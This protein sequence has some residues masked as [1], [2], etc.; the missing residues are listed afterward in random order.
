M[1]SKLTELLYPEHNTVLKT[2]HDW[3]EYIKRYKV[4]NNCPRLP[5]AIAVP[6]KDFLD[7]VNNFKQVSH[8]NRSRRKRLISLL[9]HAH[10]TNYI[11][12][13]SNPQD[14][15]LFWL[16]THA[17]NA[18]NALL[19]EYHDFCK[20]RHEQNPEPYETWTGN[21]PKSADNF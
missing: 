21:N 11:A 12:R 9:T 18:Y 17:P 2:A 6:T 19:A 14:H 13:K 10:P 8:S 3:L 1:P 16:T 7:L 4:R 15:F 20:D 5:V